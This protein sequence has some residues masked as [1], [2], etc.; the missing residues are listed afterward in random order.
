M[1]DQMKFRNVRLIL[2]LNIAIGLL[3]VRAESW[4]FSNGIKRELA[5]I[6]LIGVLIVFVP[7]LVMKVPVLNQL[8]G[9]TRE[10]VVQWMKKYFMQVL[11][12]CAALL[13]CFICGYLL[14]IIVSA[15]FG[16]SNI[17][18]AYM[19]SRNCQLPD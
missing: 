2:L 6:F 12:G 19:F 16:I 11:Y 14:A 8:V 1:T 18:I 4:N 13:I 17:I 3:L 9:K 15:I 10:A 7:L 5:L